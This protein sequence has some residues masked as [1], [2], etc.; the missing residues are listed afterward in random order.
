[1]SRCPA[2]R[3]TSEPLRT[4]GGDGELQSARSNVP[5]R[6]EVLRWLANAAWKLFVPLSPLFSA[7]VGP[8]REGG[9]GGGS[10]GQKENEKGEI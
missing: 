1:M 7:N 3:S 6:V 2:R 5:N 8:E 9:V 10:S 4:K